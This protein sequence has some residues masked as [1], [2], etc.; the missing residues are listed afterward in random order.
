[1][2]KIWND[3]QIHIAQKD[4]KGPWK[5]NS[6]DIKNDLMLLIEVQGLEE[7]RHDRMK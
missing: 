3:K 5:H 4:P 7:N 2:P 6:Q 1:M